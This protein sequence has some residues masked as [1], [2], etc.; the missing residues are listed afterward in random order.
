MTRCRFRFPESD[1]FFKLLLLAE[2]CHTH[3]FL[4]WRKNENNPKNWY[5][6][7]YYPDLKKDDN[8]KNENDFKYGDKWKWTKKWRRFQKLSP[9]LTTILSPP[10]LITILPE[11]FWRPPTLT[12]TQ[13]MMLSLKCYQVSKPEIEFHIMNIMYAE[14]HM[15]THTENTSFSCKDNWCKALDL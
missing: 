8:L 1:T 2:Q 12:A 10:P 7:N 15:R 3:E 11:Y 5:K 14:L 13:Q 4:K 6:L 9:H